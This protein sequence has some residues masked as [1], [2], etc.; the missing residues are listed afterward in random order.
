MKIAMNLWLDTPKAEHYLRIDF[1][2]E[3]GIY[4]SKW[5]KYGRGAHRVC[6]LGLA[7]LT[8]EDAQRSFL[9]T[10]AVFIAPPADVPD[11]RPS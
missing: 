5:Q 10:C 4:C 11:W 7:Y 9:E 6:K 3:D 1:I 2:R 8:H